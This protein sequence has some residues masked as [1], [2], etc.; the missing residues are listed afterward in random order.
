MEALEKLREVDRVIAEHDL[1]DEHAERVRELVLEDVPVLDAI[2]QAGDEG[3]KPAPKAKPTDD[4]ADGLS[5]PTPSM[6]KAL[7]K[8]SE[9]YEK[10]VRGIMGSF[11]AGFVNCEDCGGLGL[12][13]PAPRPKPH[14]FFRE[15]PTCVGYG[16]VLTGAREELTGSRDCPDCAGRGYLEAM[17]DN[18]PAVEL[19]ERMREQ[20]RATQVQT[21]AVPIP[22]I[23]GGSTA[24]LTFS[25]P[26]WMGDAA[27]TP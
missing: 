8:A 16:K 7:Q 26:A 4:A 23:E 9:N 2:K 11:V 24:E 3:K 27:V 17:L 5:E 21:L 6:L 22:P 1:S 10:A 14:P 19:V 20:I 15:C 13:E 25:R 18:T 12:V